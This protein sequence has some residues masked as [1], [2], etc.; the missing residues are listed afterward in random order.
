MGRTTRWFPALTMLVILT[1]CGG[2]EPEVADPGA[3]EATAP[4]EEEAAVAPAEEED[5]A[6]EPADE[7]DETAPPEAAGSG[8]QDESGAPATSVTV[9]DTDLGE[10]LADDAGRVLYLFDPDE[11][12]DSTCYED[13]AAAWPPLPGPSEAGDGV[14]EGMLGT[15]ERDDGSTQVTYGGWPLYYYSGDTAPGDVNG[16]GLQDVWWV[17]SPEGERV[18][19]TAET[20]ASYGG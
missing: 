5:E 9:T 19:Q 20:A 15:T 13:C 11:A 12:G 16:Q 4:T 7:G 1:A 3:D 10:V 6:V 2:E 18:T 17:V 8:D 14:D